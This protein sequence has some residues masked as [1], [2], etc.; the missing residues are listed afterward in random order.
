M[1]LKAVTLKK[2]LWLLLAFVLHTVLDAGLVISVY[3]ASTFLVEAYLGVFALI[4]LGFLIFA[5]KKS[6]GDETQ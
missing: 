1:V 2:P 6:K 5:K 3:G 4:L